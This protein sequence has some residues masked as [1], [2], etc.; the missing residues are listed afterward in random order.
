MRNG[1]RE[2]SKVKE[3]EAVCAQE[4]RGIEE[5]WSARVVESYFGENHLGG[6]K[7]IPGS[8]QGNKFMRLEV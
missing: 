3:L 7:Q 4:I 6:A 2:G 1:S 5:Q 8:T